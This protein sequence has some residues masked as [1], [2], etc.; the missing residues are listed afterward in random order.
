MKAWVTYASALYATFAIDHAV[1]VYLLDHYERMRGP[2]GAYRQLLL[3]GIPIALGS[4]LLF[5]FGMR[6]LR[7]PGIAP[8][9]GVRS[10]SALS[11]VAVALLMFSVSHLTERMWGQDSVLAHSL[12]LLAMTLLSLG[13]GGV[14]ASWSGI[15]RARGATAA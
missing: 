9:L 4:G 6:L 5:L 15:G 2:G 7:L 12:D 3:A 14:A 11:G 1:D 10:A 8:R 13:F